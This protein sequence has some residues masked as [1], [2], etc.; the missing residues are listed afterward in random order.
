MKWVYYL[1]KIP[2]EVKR[3][4]SYERTPIDFGQAQIVPNTAP[5]GDLFKEKYN[6]SS[7]GPGVIDSCLSFLTYRQRLDIQMIGE[8]EVEGTRLV[9]R[10]PST[11]IQYGS[12]FLINLRNF[13]TRGDHTPLTSVVKKL[14]FLQDVSGIPLSPFSLPLTLANFLVSNKPSEFYWPRRLDSGLLNIELIKRYQEAYQSRLEWET[15]GHL[16]A[17]ENQDQIKAHLSKLL[18]R[19]PSLDPRNIITTI[20]GDSTVYPNAHP[21]SI[22]IIETIIPKDL[23]FGPIPFEGGWPIGNI[24]ESSPIGKP[25]LDLLDSMKIKYK[26]LWSFQILL[27]DTETCPF[28][29]LAAFLWKIEEEYKKEIDPINIKF[30]HFTLAGHMMHAHL[31]VIRD[32]EG[33]LIDKIE[34]S[35]DYNPPLAVAIK[36][37][38][39]CDNYRASI[40]VNSVVALRE[41]AV[42]LT[43]PKNGEALFIAQG[44]M[45]KES[46]DMTVLLSNWRDLPG[47]TSVKEY[48]KEYKDGSTVPI[49]FTSHNSIHTGNIRRDLGKAFRETH[50]ISPGPYIRNEEPFSPKMVGGTLRIRRLVG[51][52]IEDPIKSLPPEIVPPFGLNINPQGRR[53]ELWLENYLDS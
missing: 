20:E 18:T 40:G 17:I 14:N 21:G 2:F 42:T 37:L 53:E 46:G 28:R 27:K 52:Y 38:T 12:S 41:D 30:L 49:T 24:S 19:V 10:S 39:L 7:W 48:L 4:R 8:T 1:G 16:E 9:F 35:E 43:T 36:S 26:I 44:F 5:F 22:Y 33:Y 50:F 3:V 31:N 32:G 34:T 47:E 6:F 11:A 15:M 13:V 45:K 29:D 51:D 23:K 25:F